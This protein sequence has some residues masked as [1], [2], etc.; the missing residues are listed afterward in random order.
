[1]SAQ[2]STAARRRTTTSTRRRATVPQQTAT[3][4]T[5]IGGV[6]TALLQLCCVRYFEAIIVR[7]IQQR[8]WLIYVVSIPLIYVF[9]LL[10][11]KN[12]DGI[13]NDD[14]AALRLPITATSSSRT[15]SSDSNQ[16][17]RSFIDPVW[18]DWGSEL[19][20]F[21]TL[22]PPSEIDYSIER[23]LPWNNNP[24]ARTNN[25][26]H[27]KCSSTSN[28]PPATDSNNKCDNILLFLPH[29]F[30]RNG[31]GSQINSYLLTVM[32]ATYMDKAMLV[33]DPPSK[34]SK[35]PNGSQFGCPIDAFIN[36]NEVLLN[37]ANTAEKKN[38]N[39]DHH[40]KLEMKPNF[41]TGLSRLLIHPAWLSRNCEIPK[42]KTFDY[43]S[44]EKIRQK[45]SRYS[46]NKNN[47]NISTLPPRQII[48]NEDHGV[49]VKVTVLGGEEVRQYFEK[50]YKSKM[51]DR[52]TV[53]SREMAYSWAIRL[54]ATPYQA[55]IFAY[56]LTNE[57]DIWDYVSA[58]LGRSGLVTFQ[59]WI[60]RDVREF[61]K[62]SQ[63]PLESSHDA[64]HVRRG[65]K[66]DA[67]A[68]D[69]V[70]TYWHS[71]GYERQK[72]FPLNYIP[73]SHFMR[74]YE[75]DC[76]TND[77]WGGKLLMKDYV[78]TIYL[79]T[80]DPKTVKKEIAKLP[81]GQGGT[82][83]VGGCERVKFV[84]S[85]DARHGALHISDGGIR[86]DC[87]ER[88]CVIFWPFLQV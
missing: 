71:Q 49:T 19:S 25:N 73:F 46:N 39:M 51:L 65:D 57:S 2:S 12:D 17:W 66:L 40:S 26:N 29:S 36:P 56:Q 31:H 82:T 32:L 16:Q 42:C 11:V 24:Q 72:D 8:R 87:V 85:P 75:K 59:P 48:C 4:A 55:N 10:L 20:Q 15:A 67:E 35:Y 80:D 27:Q 50:Q 37:S 84:F 54:G 7:F 63:L 47:D 45:M 44:W 52:S 33:L 61:I 14:N 69:E 5:P 23:R 68:R 43:A 81:R 6:Y 60:A 77:V 28:T 1:M 18:S 22:V 34:Y 78:R 21:T 41:P 79:A 30:A 53:Q 70:V 64:I 38:I 88:E 74:V 3:T 83:I 76:P 62:V 58:L 9:Y 13:D 86:V